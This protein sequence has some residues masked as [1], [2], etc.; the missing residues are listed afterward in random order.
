[1]SDDSDIIPALV[2]LNP[3][4]RN[5]AVAPPATEISPP[6]LSPTPNCRILNIGALI[7]RLAGIL[8][9]IAGFYPFFWTVIELY[10]KLGGDQK[11]VLN[12]TVGQRTIRFHMEG[13]HAVIFGL[14]W[15]LALWA[16]ATVAFALGYALYLVRELVKKNG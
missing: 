2:D 5:D 3:T 14:I 13:W 10:W 7:L 8:L 11:D 1:M 9:I 6:R 15:S 4:Q 16:A 12:V